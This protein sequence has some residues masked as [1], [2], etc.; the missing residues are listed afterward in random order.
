MNPKEIRWPRL[1]VIGLVA[2]VISG[3]IWLFVV[4]SGQLVASPSWL[5]GML[6]LVMAALVLWF[7]RPVRQHLR[8]SASSA[9]TEQALRAARAVVLAQASALTGAAVTGWYLGQLLVVLS[10]LELI[11]NHERAWWLG[12]Q[13]LVALLLVAAG[14]VAQSWCRV[15]PPPEDPA[16]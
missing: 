5:A 15:P 3:A 12:L 4:R 11:A 2:T 13:V 6:L 7:A 10:D 8:G 9:T 14:L 16:A 1:Q